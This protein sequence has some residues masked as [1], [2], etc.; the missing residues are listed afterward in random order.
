MYMFPP[1]PSMSGYQLHPNRY[2]PTHA[3]MSP[4]MG[5][6]YGSYQERGERERCASRR[7]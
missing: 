4:Y 5:Y 7:G 1:P 2:P 3:M 6:P